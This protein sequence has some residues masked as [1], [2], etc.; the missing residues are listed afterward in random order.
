MEEWMIEAEQRE[1]YGLVLSYEPTES[2]LTRG[3]FEFPMRV[4]ASKGM[5]RNCTIFCWLARFATLKCGVPRKAWG[6]Y[7]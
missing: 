2:K 6:A 5:K 4:V 7:F 1:K 3:E